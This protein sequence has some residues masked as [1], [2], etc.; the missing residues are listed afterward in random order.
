MAERAAL[1]AAGVM[2]F[3][4]MMNDGGGG[5]HVSKSPKNPC[6][7]IPVKAS[8]TLLP[9]LHLEHMTLLW[10]KL[11]RMQGKGAGFVWAM[12]KR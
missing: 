1:R 5:R 11:G 10:V 8:P 6:M 9:A 12:L 7:R 2:V 3:M 4:D